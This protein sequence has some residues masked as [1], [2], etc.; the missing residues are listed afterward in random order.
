MLPALGLEPLGGFR[1]DAFALGPAV[2]YTPKIGNTDVNFIGKYII[3][4]THTNRF[5]SNYAMVS[6]AF[7]F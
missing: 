6:V 1:A 2:L 3:D 4:V 7:K 5:N